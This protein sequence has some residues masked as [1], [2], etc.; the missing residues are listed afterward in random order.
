MKDTP[1][2]EGDDQRP[3]KLFSKLN[4]ILLWIFDPVNRLFDNENK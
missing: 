3:V 2:C 1:N 4:Q